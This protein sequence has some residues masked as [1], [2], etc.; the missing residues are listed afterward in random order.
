MPVGTKRNCY[1][2]RG[3]GETRVEDRHDPDAIS[4]Q[5]LNEVAAAL[6]QWEKRQA[7]PKPKKPAAPPVWHKQDQ[8]RIKLPLW[9]LLARSAVAEGIAS[10]LIKRAGGDTTG[11]A[12]MVHDGESPFA[13]PALW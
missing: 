7:Q 1:V 13:R 3:S 12:D 11:W 4:I 2:R 10:G 9:V 6:K 5:D 8:V